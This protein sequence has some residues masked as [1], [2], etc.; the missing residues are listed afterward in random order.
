MKPAD[1]MVKQLFAMLFCKG[2]V[3]MR[4]KCLALAVIATLMAGCQG[5]TVPS[6]P[7]ETLLAAPLQ[8]SVGSRIMTLEPFVWRDFMPV[9]PPGGTELMANCLI[10]AEDGQPYPSG[11][12]AD[13]I[14]VIAGD[15]VWEGVFTEEA[16]PPGPTRLYQLQKLAYGGPKWDVGTEVEVVVRLRPSTGSPQLLRATGK[17]IGMTV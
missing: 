12:D 3:A 7:L 14:W 5:T 6:L 17:K 16:G 11:L 2:G 1:I 8:V 4:Y 13:K 9:S 10:T 15:E